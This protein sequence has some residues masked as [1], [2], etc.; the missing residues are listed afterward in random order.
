[1]KSVAVFF[2]FLTGVLVMSS[3]IAAEPAGDSPGAAY[4]PAAEGAMVAIR[5][6]TLKPGVDATAFERF[7]ARE[8]VPN[9]SLF[10]PGARVMVA[11]GERGKNVGKYL[12]LYVFDS[13]NVRDLYWPKPDEYSPTFES[14]V[15][16]YG[17]VDA[18]ME[19]EEKFAQYAE[20]SE[21]YTDYAAIE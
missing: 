15:E 2:T 12:L 18:F 11:K 6:V 7:V 8:Y 3:W 4:A 9:A 21:D 10:W 14:I 1:M 5:D 17:G 13:K 19:L 20:I 16:A